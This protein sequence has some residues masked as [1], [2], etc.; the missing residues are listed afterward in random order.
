MKCP[1]GP[2][3]QP[4]PQATFGTRTHGRRGGVACHPSRRCWFPR[5]RLPASTEP[6]IPAAPLLPRVLV[7]AVEFTYTN[8]RSFGE[9]SNRGYAAETGWSWWGSGVSST[10]KATYRVLHPLNPLGRANMHR[11][12]PAGPMFD[13][14]R[15][16]CDTPGHR[17]FDQQKPSP[18]FP[19]ATR[20]ICLVVAT[21]SRQPA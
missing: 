9:D 4:E 21:T 6:Q 2:A 16:V 19:H 10:N 7:T 5:E 1:S 17:A 14:Y 13:T 15:W 18:L 11:S 3:E 12:L 20:W 8:H